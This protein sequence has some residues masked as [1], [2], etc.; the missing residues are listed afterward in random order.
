MKTLERLTNIISA[1]CKVG[2]GLSFAILIV[3]VL[4]QVVGRTAGSSPVW[5]EELTRFSLLYLAA[6]GVGLSFRSGDLV[7]VDVI[8][9][10]LPGRAPWVLRLISALLTAAVALVL[11]P[12]AWKFTSIGKMQTSP[13]LG[14]RMDAVH[15]TVTLL[16]ALLFVFA[17]LRVV[18]MLSGRSDGLPLKSQEE[19]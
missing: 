5:T 1:I 14:L 15:F 16:L 8:C 9:E 17:A 4:I 19:A 10:S 18:N 12:H 3:V 13:A 2:V 7:N 6:F 11:I